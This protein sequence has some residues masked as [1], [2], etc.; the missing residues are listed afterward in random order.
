MSD[1]IDVDEAASEL[2]QPENPEKA[3][4]VDSVPSMESGNEA[5]DLMSDIKIKFEIKKEKNMKRARPQV[6]RGKKILKGPKKALVKT[7]GGLYKCPHCP[8]TFEK[9]QSL[10]G[11]KSKAHAGQSED[12]ARKMRIREGRTD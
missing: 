9:Y 11:H 10:G 2:D 3:G 5:H 12:Y 1:F 4:N 7:S 8:M 6:K